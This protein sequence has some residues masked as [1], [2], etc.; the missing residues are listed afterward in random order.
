MKIKS[1]ALLVASAILL[2]SAL[3]ITATSCSSGNA[4]TAD[5]PQAA[6][7]PSPAAQTLSEDAYKAHMV[8]LAE[9]I[10]GEIYALQEL[11]IV[12]DLDSEEWHEEVTLALSEIMALCDAAG[13]L[14]P[15]DSMLEEHLTYLE[16]I[17]HITGAGDTVMSGM[18]DEDVTL[19]DQA[20]AELWIASEMLCHPGEPGA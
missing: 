12:P 3:G 15:P 16:T 11:L 7:D 19:L 20:S 2:A 18:E 14:V 9:K 13:Q 6:D 17:V 10:N 4:P 1:K 5:G 8:S